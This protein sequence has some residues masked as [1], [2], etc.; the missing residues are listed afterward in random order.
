M[1]KILAGLD[2]YQR[3]VFPSL[4]PEVSAAAIGPQRPRAL[5]ITCADSRVTPTLITQTNPGDLF[6]CQVVGNIVPAY[7]ATY[8]GVS[9]T[10]EYALAVLEIPHIIVCGHSDCG[11]MKVLLD[12]SAVEALPHIRMWIDHAEAARLTVMENWPDEDD[13]TKLRLLTEH[14]VI[15]QLMHLRTHPSVASRLVSGKLQIHGWVYELH[16]GQVRVYQEPT[17]TFVPATELL[18][19]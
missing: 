1:E 19:R 16:T 9:A 12:V 5:F 17:G 18:G 10:I 15:A 13:D 14:N 11:A 3:E 8:G 7:G 6:G 2:R 4:P